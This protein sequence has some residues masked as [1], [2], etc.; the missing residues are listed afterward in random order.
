[1]PGGTLNAP[2]AVMTD[3][4]ADFDAPLMRD[5]AKTLQGPVILPDD[6]AYDAARLVWNRAIDRRPAAIVRCASV[7]DVRRT[8]ELARQSAL[9]LAVR[10]GGHSQA[11]HGVCDGGIVIDLGGLRGIHVD[12]PERLLRVAA[13]A[14]V[15]D[16]MDALQPRGLLT[17]MGGCPD[18]GV[19]GLTL[20]GGANFLMA[21]YGAV[22]DNLL[23]ADI[24]AADGHVLTA[25]MEE[26]A[27]LFWAIRGG[28]GNFGVVTSF[29]YRL[30]AIG[31]VGFGQFLFPPSHARDALRRYRDLMRDAPDELTTSGG[32]SVLGDGPAFF[33]AFC[34]CGE[35]SAGEPLAGAWRTALRPASETFTWAPYSSDLVVAPAPSVGSGIF[36]PA[37]SDE[38][39]EIY[40]SAVNDAP[41]SASAVWNDF[42]GAVTRVAPEATAFPLR[43]RGFDLFISVPFEGKEAR[44]EAAAWVD[45]LAGALRPFGAGVYVNN[46]NEIERDRVREA[47][48]PNYERLAKIKARYDPENLFRVN[49]NI[50]PT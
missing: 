28:G 5:W 9:T 46:L 1:M 4:C 8:I 48:G 15:I 24:V 44:R 23:A 14:R 34:F 37:L 31:D 32:L 29:E 39:I 25:S 2:Q 19:G 16:V 7:D 50:P 38:V 17:P 6:T 36:L 10:G 18:V 30:H 12:D 35:R 22:V 49:H 21:R 27:D 11:G 43:R 20:G 41:T 33:I 47:Y 3:R 40:S 26:N 13:G 42:H 45:R